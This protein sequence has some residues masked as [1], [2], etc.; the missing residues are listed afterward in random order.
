[1]KKLYSIHEICELTSVSVRTLHYYDEANILKPSHRANNGH[2]LYS[3]EDLFCLQQILTFK[4]LGFTLGQIKKIIYDK[5]V[6]IL[7]SLKMQKKALEDEAERIK[8]ATHFFNYFIDTYEESKEF[9]WENIQN[10]M[11]VFKQKQKDINHFF[12]KYLTQIEL[13]TFDKAAKTRTEKWQALVQEV[14][15]KLNE[16]ASAEPEVAIVRKWVALAD[17]TYGDQP[18]LKTKLWKAYQAGAIPNSFFPYDKEVVAYL[19]K[20]FRKLN[21]EEGV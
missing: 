16:N 19:A 4:F 8:K 21:N 5:N 9:D 10:I 14:R 12:Q 13:E 17:E 20:A 6:D 18:E 1:M 3:Q 7:Q 15:D 11:T 2:R